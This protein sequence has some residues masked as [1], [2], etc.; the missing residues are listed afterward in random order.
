A[1][2]AGGS[3]AGGSS[4]GVTVHL[5]QT[6]QTIQGFG[7]NDNWGSQFSGTVADSLFTTTGTGIGLSILRTGMN[8]NGQFYN[9]TGETTGNMAAVKSRAGTNAKI[10]GSVWS[11]PAN[12]KTNNIN[13]G[14]P[15]IA[16][17]GHL[18]MSCYES[19]STTIANFAGNNGF[20]AMSIGNEPD[21][22]SCGSADPCNGNYDTTLFTAN[23]MVMFVK[24]AG[25]KL[26]AK[27]VKVIAPEA[28]EWEHT[29]S[30]M[31]A[32]PD[33]GG[34]DSSD[35]LKCGCFPDKATACAAAC[36]TGGGYDYGH[37]LAKDTTAW[38]AFD[39]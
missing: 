15:S 24:I 14:Q 21:F 7:I 33:V 10:I 12:C 13:G 17:G 25:P 26:K 39:I 38:G 20:Y 35:P 36:T 29:W 32:G 1:T 27:N 19:W 6:H 3:A 31:S 4:G 11:P 23:E 9:G 30:N 2:G 34:K 28:S 8:P 18:L 37:W 22:A 16:D 5:D